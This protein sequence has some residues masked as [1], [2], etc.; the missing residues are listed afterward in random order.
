MKIFHNLENISRVET[1]LAS[2][3]E[4]TSLKSLFQRMGE[5]EVGKIASSVSNS[6]LIV[7]GGSGCG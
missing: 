7:E 1:Y 2:M 5:W 3:D 4:T 6:W